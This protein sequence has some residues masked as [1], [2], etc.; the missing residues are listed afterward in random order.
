MALVNV[1]GMAGEIVRQ[2]AADVANFDKLKKKK[3]A[4]RTVNF[5]P[6]YSALLCSTLLYS[7]LLYSALLYST[8][9]YKILGAFFGT[10]TIR[11]L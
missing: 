9:L 3:G 5:T 8:L 1:D 10:A 4:T 2:H 11:N 7:T 6:L